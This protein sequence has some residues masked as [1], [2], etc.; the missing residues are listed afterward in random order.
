MP[1]ID[2]VEEFLDASRKSFVELP[3]ELRARR[4]ARAAPYLVPS[5]GSSDENG[6]SPLETTFKDLSTWDHRRTRKV[7][8]DKPRPRKLSEEKIRVRKVSEK[9][10]KRSH[11]S[12]LSLPSRRFN[13]FTDAQPESPTTPTEEGTKR[14]PSSLNSTVNSISRA[15]A[16]KKLVEKLEIPTPPLRD[17]SG[18]ENALRPKRSI[19]GMLER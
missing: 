9:K 13:P 10:S 15:R 7:S 11:L 3:K 12:A 5:S 8:D 1:E 6:H 18:K 19:E 14:A 2:Q 16:A 4:R 17:A